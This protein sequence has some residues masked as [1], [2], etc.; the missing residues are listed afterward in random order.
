MNYYQAREIKDDAGAGTGVWHFTCRN[1]DRIWPTGCDTGCRHA[2]AEEACQHWVELQIA[3]GVRHGE[4]SWTT[5]QNREGLDETGR[6]K[7]CPKPAHQVLA[8]GGP[9]G[10]DCALCDDHAKDGIA[11]ALFRLSHQGSFEIMSS[12]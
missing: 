9:N 4:C 10:H 11:E 12:W 6:P 5:C 8:I 7:S 3:K 1:D 2:T